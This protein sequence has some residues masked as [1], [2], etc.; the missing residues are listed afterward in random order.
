MKARAGILIVALLVTSISVVWAQ[1]GG[2]K[3]E[4]AEGPRVIAVKFHADWCGFCKAMGS[5]FEELQAK[6]DTQPVLYIT[7]DHTREFNRKQSK[8]MA[9]SLGLSKVW[10]E[11][12][13]K[14]GFV[15]LINGTTLEVISMLTHEQNLKQMGTDLLMA[16]EKTAAKK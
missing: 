4:T 2:A 9:H 10:A 5:A 7:L 16:V 13:G 11:H 8:Y 6:F 15:L 3:S 1:T 14:T 12:G